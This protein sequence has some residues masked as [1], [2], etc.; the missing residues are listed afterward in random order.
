M[1]DQ[2]DGGQG[3]VSKSHFI[4]ICQKAVGW[5]RDI[6]CIKEVRSRLSASGCNHLHECS[7]VV[8]VAMGGN[9]GLDAVGSN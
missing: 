9:H 2:V 1:P 6:G 8:M 3:A 7:P 5:Y 4:L